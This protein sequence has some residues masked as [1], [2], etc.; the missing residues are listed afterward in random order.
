MSVFAQHAEAYAAAGLP[1]FPVN[2]RNKRPAIL[3]WR[4]A[5]P[6]KARQWAQNERLREADGLGL[7]MGRPSG[8]TEIDVDGAG[9]AWLAAAIERFGETPIAIRTASG[10]FKLWY[11][12]NSEGRHI[13]PFD[14]LPIDVLGDGFTIAPPSWREDLGAAYAFISGSIEAIGNLPTLREAIQ[15]PGETV[16]TGK[17][18]DT[19]WRY[20]MAH[21]RHCDDVEALID[22]AATWAGA[23]PDPLPTSEIERCA[24]SAWGY[25]ATGRNYLGLRK[26][27]ITGG[28]RMMDALID[29]PDALVL[30]QYFRRWH[31]NRPA[32]AIAP[33]AMSEAGSPPWHWTRIVKARDI[34]LERRFLEE[35]SAPIRG[36]K[37]GRYR[38]QPIMSDSVKDHYTPSPPVL[39]AD[40]LMEGERA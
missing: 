4:T 19:L 29:E 14:G 38:L 1:A 28:D 32:F 23:F 21:A 26:P 25:E 30:L 40:E 2:T 7:L 11:Q 39:E 9:E 3:G 16:G 27:Q 15:R 10:K 18:N 17:R 5:T 6:Q 33:R 12:H 35:L 8:I 34:L 31:S 24:R 20:C 36:H 22:V 37:A 13:R